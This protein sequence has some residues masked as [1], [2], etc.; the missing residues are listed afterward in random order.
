VRL[1]SFQEL[2]KEQDGVYTLP[3]DGSHLITGP[4]GTGKTV[5]A[6]YRA[7]ALGIDDRSCTIL[8][9]SKVLKQYTN[10][11]A[12]EVKALGSV[13]TFH[14][15]F[16]G[17]WRKY[18]SGTPP[19]L[20]GDPWAFDWSEI[21]ARFTSSP[22]ARDTL[23]DLLIDEGQDLS[24]RFYQLVR[25]IAPNITVFADENQ[26]L[27]PDNSTIEEIRV[28]LGRRS[29]VHRLTR[30]YRNTAEIARL[31]ARFYCGA[32]TGI[33]EPPTREGEVPVLR[34]FKNLTDLVEIVSRYEKTYSDRSIGV[35]AP[36]K[37]TQKSLYNRLS[38]RT[39]KNP[40]QAYISGQVEHDRID[41][42]MPGIKILNYWTAKGLEFDSLFVPELQ[43][44]TGD[45]SSAE[46]KMRFYVVF[47]RAREELFLSYTGDG[48]E[49]PLVADI[50]DE[51]L[52]R[53]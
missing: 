50:P 8:M 47:S 7:Q 43:Q 6:L 16:W 38:A 22:P 44:V 10:L 17:F 35:I 26:K 51:I 32:P 30:N 33:P 29:E 34:N 14:S 41:F 48:G 23:C 5:M 46:I 11:A 9:H 1:P 18:Y 39:P 42:N 45:S 19:K 3:L 52:E 13:E 40:V 4:P 53:A 36:N 28:A 24:P 15:W 25:M 31:A 49:P 21:T 37:K 27:F 2:S 12:A 20:D